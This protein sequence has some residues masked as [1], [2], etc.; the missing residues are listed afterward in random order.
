MMI[1]A[2]G[3]VTEPFYCVTEL[4]FCDGAIGDFLQSVTESVTVRHTY[5]RAIY[6]R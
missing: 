4:S 5:F 3:S 1:L 2:L 6:Q